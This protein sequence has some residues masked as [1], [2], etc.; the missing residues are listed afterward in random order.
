[1]AGSKIT[2]TPLVDLNTIEDIELRALAFYILG[3]PNEIFK[4]QSEDEELFK[5]VLELIS[6]KKE[7]L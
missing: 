1:M 4:L 5:K 3:N 6:I 7:F 2:V